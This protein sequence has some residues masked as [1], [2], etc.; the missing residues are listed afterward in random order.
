MEL[1]HINAI[2]DVFYW[3]RSHYPQEKFIRMATLAICYLVTITETQTK[4]V[5]KRLF[6]LKFT[7]RENQ[8]RQD[9]FQKSGIKNLDRVDGI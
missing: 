8:V 4:N 6:L 5:N 3:Q 7:F 2:K 1:I 9:S